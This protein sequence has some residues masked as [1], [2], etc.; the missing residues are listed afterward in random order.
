MINETFAKM[1]AEEVKNKL[2]PSQKETLLEEQNW[3][4]WQEAL[5]ALA[6]NL[7]LQI[8]QI[9]EE[10]KIEHD[11]YTSLGGDGDGLAM[12]SSAA[13][14]NRASK[15]D[16][17]K[18]HVERRLDD[19]TKMIESGVATESDGWDEVNFYRRAI[20]EHK[21]LMREYDLE[22]TPIDKAL[23]AALEKKWDFD[24][25]SMTLS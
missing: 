20:H 22:E 6:E 16:R 18:F 21:V 10:E 23:W 25:I 1:V 24:K 17:F 14:A 3:N 9:K 12:R 13:Y 2:S 19:V 5:V 11:R 15:I 4:R 8:K 7:E